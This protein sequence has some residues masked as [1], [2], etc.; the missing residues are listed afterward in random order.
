MYCLIQVNWSEKK[1]YLPSD[2]KDFGE[3]LGYNLVKEGMPR[4]MVSWQC[5][6]G[7]E[8]FSIKSLFNASEI[9]LEYLTNLS[10]QPVARGRMTKIVQTE[11]VVKGSGVELSTK[12]NGAPVSNRKSGVRRMSR[13]Q[14]QAS[15]RKLN[16]RKTVTGK[17]KS[18]IE[19]KIQIAEYFI[20]QMYLAADL[21]LDR[22]YVAI[23]ML[24]ASFPIDS[25]FSILRSSNIPGK[26]KAAVC[27]LIRTLYLDREPQ[28]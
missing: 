6:V 17:V 19:R 1:L 3:V 12:R 4:M 5:D 18:T 2:E 20:A 14:K 16:T 27:R 21:C 11:A 26:F 23:G 7:E 10:I 8:D 15:A 24:E 25:L 22:N 13:F 9:P 28:V